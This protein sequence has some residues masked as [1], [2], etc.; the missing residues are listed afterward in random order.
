MNI[1]KSKLIKIGGIMNC[2]FCGRKTKK[3]YHVS[4]IIQKRKKPILTLTT[5]E[6]CGLYVR[7]LLPRILNRFC[8]EVK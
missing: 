2:E 6:V 4:I 3:K 5:C 1:I 8:E 7:M